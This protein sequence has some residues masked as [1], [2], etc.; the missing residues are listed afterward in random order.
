[1]L[2]ELDNDFKVLKKKKKKKLNDH[3]PDP[4]IF[5]LNHD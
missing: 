5:V 3:L 4:I 1:M 2:E